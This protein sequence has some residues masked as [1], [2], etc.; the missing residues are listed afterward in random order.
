MLPRGPWRIIG[1]FFEE[2]TLLKVG[3]ILMV[4]AFVLSAGVA[5]AVLL[6]ADNSESASAPAEPVTAQ[7]AAQQ[8]E[9][10]NGSNSDERLKIDREESTT[11]KKVPDFAQNWSQ[12]STSEAA[13]ANAPRYYPP[14]RDSTLTLTV[15]AIGLY[16]VPV[17]N[18][19][20]QEALAQGVIHL[21]E[22]P[23]P[24]EEREQK[25]VYIAGH[26]LGYEGTG[27]RLVFYNLNKLKKGDSVILKDSLGTPYEYQV[28]EIFVA[29]PNADWTVDPVRGRDMVTLQTCTMPDFRNRL[30]VRADRVY[31]S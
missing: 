3:V 15:P 13:A 23:F 20:T 17:I 28:S 31:P 7:S 26:R 4:V 9:K 18:S 24:W 6:R 16:E 25:N 29:D 5:G 1:S 14:Q 2:N 19:K 22:T 12:P 11:E 30:V 8:G 21:P 10:G 27:S